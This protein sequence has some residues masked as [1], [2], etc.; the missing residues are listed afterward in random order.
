[1]KRRTFLKILGLSFLAPKV[2]IEAVE[3]AGEL[4]WNKRII[5]K[6]NYD[7]KRYPA[8]IKVQPDPFSDRRLRSQ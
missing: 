4:N 3:K 8:S 1:M 2:G 7:W 6:W 5:M